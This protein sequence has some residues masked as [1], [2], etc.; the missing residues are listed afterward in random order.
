MKS[1]GSVQGPGDVVADQVAEAQ[2]AR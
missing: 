2:P 1:D